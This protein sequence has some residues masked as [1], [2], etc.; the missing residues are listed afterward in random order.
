M[1]AT[2]QE[3]CKIILHSMTEKEKREEKQ[4]KDLARYIQ[5]QEQQN[6]YYY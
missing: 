6:K 4:K 3:K 2:K 1:R 5:E